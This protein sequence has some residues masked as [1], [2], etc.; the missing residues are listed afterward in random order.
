MNHHPVRI[1]LSLCALFFLGGCELTSANDF[2]EE[3]QQTRFENNASVA[4]TVF[5]AE[6]EAL[7]EF[8]LAPEGIQSV[9]RS[10][11]RATFTFTP[12]TVQAAEINEQE[13]V[14]TDL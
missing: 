11:A 3:D 4:V 8:T 9:E 13:I 1:L 2:D 10:G 5:P 12:D 6:E 7:E 14:F